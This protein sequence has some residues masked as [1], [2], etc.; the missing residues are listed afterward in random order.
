MQNTG[1]QEPQFANRP[2][3][4]RIPD[5]HSFAKTRTTGEIEVRFRVN[6]NCKLVLC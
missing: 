6:H 2:G 3:L 5:P 4:L 1:Y